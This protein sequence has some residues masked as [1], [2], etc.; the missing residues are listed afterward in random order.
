[1]IWP[2]L[3][4]PPVLKINMGNA[5]YHLRPL[6]C[7]RNLKKKAFSKLLKIIKPFKG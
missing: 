7:L 4:K 3:P 5:R 6:L 2:G 1:M